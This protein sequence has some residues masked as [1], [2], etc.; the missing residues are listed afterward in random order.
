VDLSAERVARND[1][2]F[3]DANEA[4]AESAAEHDLTDRVPFICECAE[5]TCTELVQLSLVEY[6]MVRADSRR[7]LNAPGHEVAGGGHVAVVE[8]RD[9]YVVVEKVGEAGKIAEELDARDAAVGDA[10]ERS[11]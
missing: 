6:E 4:I 3:R 7:F 10:G 11:P 5:P 9:G 1:S 8:R 2:V